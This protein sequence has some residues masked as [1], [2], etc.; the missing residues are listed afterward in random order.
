MK[1]LIERITEEV[2]KAFE[3]AGYDPALGQVN[4]SNRPDLCEYQCNG[5]MAGAK[6]YGKAPIAIAGDVAA[7][8]EGNAAFESVEAVPPGFLNITLTPEFIRGFIV[9]A[10]RT[11]RFGVDLPKPS[12]K[13]ILDYGGPNIAK[14]L[15]VGHLRSAIIGESLKRIL[16]YTGNEVIGDIHMGD[17]GMPMGLVITELKHRHP[18]WPYFDENADTSAFPKEPL[19]DVAELEEVYPYAS[20]MS[21]EDEAYKKEAMEAT[22]LLQDGD[23]GHRALWRQIMEVSKA[24]LKKNY[25]ALAVSFDLWW[26]E[27]DVHDYIPDMVDEMRRSGVAVESD[28]ALVIEVSEETDTKEVPPCMVLK[29]DGA[30]LYNTTDLA[31]IK[32]RM[33]EMKPDAM[34]YLTDKRQDLYFEQV[35]R[36]A[37]RSR[38][39]MPETGLTHIGFGTMNGKDGKPF[40]TREG[41]AP[42]LE[43]LISDIEAQ[44]EERIREGNKDIDDAEVKDTAH[45]IALSAIKYGDLS[46]QPSKDYVFDLD[47]FTS[48][49]GDTGPYILYTIVRIKSILRRYTGEKGENAVKEAKLSD[50]ISKSE[51]A[52]ALQL[53]R[54]ADSVE[55]AASDLQP[56]RICSYIYA[57]SNCFNS[58]YHETKI[59]TEEDEVRK[60]SYIALLRVT[61]KVL[62]RAI[63]LLGFDAPDRM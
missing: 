5:A 47:K 1:K 52:L 13:I 57:L 17:W 9:E 22:R 4:V 27:S 43:L 15:H 34:I 16:R 35:F 23:K 40:K 51:K 24:D 60:D 61:L 46:N 38:L 32:R 8:L 6:R 44:M 7:K 33:E 36:A 11:K 58:F 49:E 45:K 19:F 54:F 39:V 12:P 55:A 20:A 29:S 30:A 28:G 31:T 63:D 37:K 62:E 56:N 59:L 3:E 25:D 53:T 2:A 42:R 10:D 14:P 41:T 26:G 48:F 18:E 21:K 50:A